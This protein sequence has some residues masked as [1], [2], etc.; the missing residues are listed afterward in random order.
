MYQVEQWISTIELNFTTQDSGNETTQTAPHYQPWHGGNTAA[1]GREAA[2]NT[3]QPCFS[4]LPMKVKIFL[5][6]LLH[7]PTN[8]DQQ[9]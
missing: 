4:C 1:G 6:F 9:G 8:M 5:S 2:T 3:L 7:F